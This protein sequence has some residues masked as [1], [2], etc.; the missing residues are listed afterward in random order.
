MT[1]VCNV[2]T[3]KGD[4]LEFAYIPYWREDCKLV[5]RCPDCGSE[6]VSQES[7]DER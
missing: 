5:I 1:V 3:R 7:C 2:C 4:S 6:S